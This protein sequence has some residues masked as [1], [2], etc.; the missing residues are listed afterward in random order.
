MSKPMLK[1]V[2]VV[3]LGFVVIAILS[4]ITDMV[5]EN[6][7]VLPKGALPLTGSVGLLVA[8]LAYR[9]LY[10]LLG[11]YVVARLAPNRPMKHALALGVVGLIFTAL[12]PIAMQDKAPAWYSV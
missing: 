3:I 9:A 11:C 1:S 8:V 12:Q 6:T 10:S 5:L 4:G 2:G 7:G